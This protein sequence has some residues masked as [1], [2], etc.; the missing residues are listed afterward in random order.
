MQY[1][2]VEAKTWKPLASTIP[3][4]GATHYHCAT[5]AGNNLYVA[6]FDG[7]HHIYRYDTEG[8]I[9]EKQPHLCGEISN[10]CT[11]DD[12]MYAISYDCNQVPQRYSFSKCQWQNFA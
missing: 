5:A 9:W 2:D 10:L 1:F 11:V 8:N 4:I 7:G 12:F 3:P 6:G